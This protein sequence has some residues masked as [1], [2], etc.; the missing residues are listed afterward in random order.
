VREQSLKFEEFKINKDLQLKR[1]QDQQR[2]E[3]AM[4]KIAQQ[5]NAIRQQAAVTK[6]AGAGSLNARYAARQVDAILL[7]TA[8]LDNI[9]ALP[10]DAKLGTFSAIASSGPKGLASAITALGAQNITSEEE[11]A[12][13]QD[14]SLIESELAILGA[15]GQSGGAGRMV[16]ELKTVRPHAGDPKTAMLKYLALA[17]QNLEQAAKGLEVWP[18]ASE[19]QKALA[20]QQVVE[21]NNIIPWSA[22]DVNVHIA[23]KAGGET[24]GDMGRATLNK[25]STTPQIPN[26]APQQKAPDAAVQ[27]LKAHPELKEQFRQKYGYLPE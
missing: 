22:K 23:G 7:S 24:I 10:A 14:A 5:A 13:Q 26:A 15:S 17:K 3:L 18:G 16:E 27:H 20:R 2:H 11:R 12:F 8:H 21:L 25:P 1:Q 19:E 4:E 6:G 9:M